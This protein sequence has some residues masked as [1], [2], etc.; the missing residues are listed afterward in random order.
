MHVDISHENFFLKDLSSRILTC[1]DDQ[2]TMGYI[3][4]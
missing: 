3:M 2:Q 4:F 1:H